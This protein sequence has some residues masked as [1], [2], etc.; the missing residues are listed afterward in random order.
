MSDDNPYSKREVDILIGGISEKFDQLF[1]M[2]DKWDNSLTRIETNQNDFQLRMSKIE[3][4]ISDYASYKK[5]VDGL[6]NY[7]WWITGVGAVI[8][9]LGGSMLLLIK[10]QIT[11]EVQSKISLAM[12]RTLDANITKQEII[13]K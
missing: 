12:E 8:I 10:A 6:V 5:I 7:K 3:D 11:S 4:M 9:L 13:N 1:K 2:L